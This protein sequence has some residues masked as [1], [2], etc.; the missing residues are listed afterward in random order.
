[1]KVICPVRGRRPGGFTLVELLVVIGIIALLISILL[2]AL[3]RAREQG[4]QIKCLSNLRQLAIAFVS[5][6]NS[7]PKSG[8]PRPAGGYGGGTPEDWI[9]WENGRDIDESRIVPYLSAKPFN[10][11]LIQCPSD[12]ME[13]HVVGGSGAFKFSYTVNM[14]ICKIFLPDATPDPAPGSYTSFYTGH[15]TMKL[16]QVRSPTDKVLLIEESS[17]SIDDGAWAWQA[18]GG[19]DKNT[20]SNRHDRRVENI[21]DKTAGRGNAAFCDGHAEFMQRADAFK[22]KYYHPLKNQ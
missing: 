2:P 14:Y 13:A 7:N 8:M 19:R 12:N 5:Y 11:S 15:K 17:E 9:Y 18:E 4:N 21:A 22:V 20:L 3:S 1:M 6:A 16:S 10:P